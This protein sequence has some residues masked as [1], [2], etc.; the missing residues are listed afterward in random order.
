MCVC[1]RGCIRWVLKK[2]QPYN[3]LLDLPTTCA[4]RLSGVE[5]RFHDF[6]V[7]APDN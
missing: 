6:N 1:E 2:R 5:R 3:Q 4:L 7:S